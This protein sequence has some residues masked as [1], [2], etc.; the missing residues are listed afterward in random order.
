MEERVGLGALAIGVI[1]TVLGFL[2][3]FNGVIW[4]LILV[5]LGLYLLFGNRWML[6]V[7]AL[8]DSVEQRVATSSWA[9]S[10]M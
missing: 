8:S 1:F 9:A 2:R 3:I 10:A 5:A 7:Y 6:K 4:P